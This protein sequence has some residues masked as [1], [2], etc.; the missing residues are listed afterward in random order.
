MCT[1][2]PLPASYRKHHL[3]GVNSNNNVLYFYVAIY[4]LLG[5]NLV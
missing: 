2:Y 1:N 3:K 5:K 4:N